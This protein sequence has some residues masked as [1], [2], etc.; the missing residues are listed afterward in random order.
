MFI[1][2]KFESM[3]MVKMMTQ[4]I[5]NIFVHNLSMYMYWKK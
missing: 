1:Q 3:M 4:M 2:E 5:V